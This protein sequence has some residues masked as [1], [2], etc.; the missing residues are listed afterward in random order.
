MSGCHSPFEQAA[1]RGSDINRVTEM[2]NIFE[3]YEANPEL[4]E[5]YNLQ[6]SMAEGKLGVGEYTYNGVTKYM[7]YYP[8]LGTGWSLGC[9][10]AQGFRY[11]QGRFLNLKYGNIIDF[12]Y[13]DRL[14]DNDIDS[15]KHI[16][17]HQGDD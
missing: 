8:V 14:R 10:S 2:Y 7:G 12:I 4:E 3:E 5:M 6:K 13:I 16:S 11:G 9:N 1:P 15:P 17:A